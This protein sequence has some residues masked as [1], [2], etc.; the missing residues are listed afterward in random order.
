VWLA[1]LVIGSPARMSQQFSGARLRAIR[2]SRQVAREGLA[3]AARVSMA[4]LTRYEQNAAVPNVNA[5]AR[6]AEALGV[7]LAELLD[8][9]S[10]PR[11]GHVGD[12]P[13]WAQSLIRELR[14]EAASNRV[15]AKEAGQAAAQ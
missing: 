3:V 14:A 13:A 2:T 9:S 12:L 1:S 5:A 11:P 7:T 4:A 10:I 6:L 8:G 15:R